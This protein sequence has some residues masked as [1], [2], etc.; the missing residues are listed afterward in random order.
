MRKFRVR[1]VA[2][3]TIVA[4]AFLM[5]AALPALAQSDECSV[6]V[7]RIVWCNFP[8]GSEPTDVGFV[9]GVTETC[10][11]ECDGG[12]KLEYRIKSFSSE[13]LTE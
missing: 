12:L 9:D 5:L 3:C 6:K 13:V 2:R 1:G 7:D 4:L 10:S 11:N 8:D